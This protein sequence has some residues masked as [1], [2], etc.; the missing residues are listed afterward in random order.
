M[1]N[2]R[3]EVYNVCLAELL[4]ERGIDALPESIIRL[5]KMPDVRIFV[6][7]VRIILEGKFYNKLK[8]NEQ[9]NER[10][11]M[12]LCDI[13]IGIIYNS[14]LKNVNTIIEIKDKFLHGKFDIILC[15]QDE[16]GVINKTI[17]SADLKAIIEIIN[18]TVTLIV[19]NNVLLKM[20]RLVEEKLNILTEY[21]SHNNIWFNDKTLLK[22]LSD[23][24]GVNSS[25]YTDKTK[26]D[27]LKMTFFVLIDAMIFQESIKGLYDTVNSLDK[28]NKPLKTYFKS[29]WDEILKI[30]YKSI[31]TVSYNVIDELPNISV[32]TDYI[33]SSLKNL[34]LMIINSGI[35]TRHDFMGRIYH[36]LLLST[37][38]Q[39]YATYYTAVPS[40]YL[41]SEL[42]FKDDSFGWNFNGLE[43]LKNFRIVD[44]AC[45]SGTLLS[46]SYISLRDLIST[47]IPY[48]KIHD[49]HKVM[50]EDVIYGWDVLGY[51]THLTHTVLGLHNP[52]TIVKSSNIATIPNGIDD[53]GKIVL[54]SITIMNRQTQ[55]VNKGLIE[56]VKI[57]SVDE[58][59][60]SYDPY[61]NSIGKFDLVIMNPPFTRSA[62]T[63][64]KFGYTEK[65]IKLM[66]DKE[67]SSILKCNGL[68]GVGQAG[69]GAAFVGLSQSLLK[70]NGVLAFIVPR[71]ILSGV[72]WSKIRDGLF[73]QFEIKY[74][75]SNYDPGNKSLGIDGWSWSE[76]T[77]LG[78]VMII[79]QKTTKVLALKDT[80]Y[81][82]LINKPQ[83]EVYS[84]CYANNIKKDN[85]KEYIIS[86]HFQDIKID[87][88]TVGYYYKVNQSVLKDNW[89]APC[90]FSNPYL[91]AL[92]LSLKNELPLVELGTLIY[93]DGVDIK[94][95]KDS[96]N[97]TNT[98]TGYSILL[99]QQSAMN[100]LVLKD[101]FISY[102]IPKTN[103]AIEIYDNCKSS[104]LLSERP[105]LGND[106]LIMYYVNKQVL[107]TAFWEIQFTEKDIEKLM[108]LWF[109][110][111]FG[112]LLYLSASTSSMAGIFKTKKK[113]LE[114]M[115]VI[116]PF[117]FEKDILN[118]VNMLYNS[119]KDEEVKKFEEEFKL[120]LK[121]RGVRY[122]IDRFFI[123]LLNIKINM[124]LYYLL[125]QNEPSI[126][127]KRL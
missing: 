46:S 1:S 21:A 2:F 103:K 48:K 110:S 77:D 123:K 63:N 84:I 68:S 60:E 100:K 61:I 8:L 38:G 13:C 125:L 45:G 70:C 106:C 64:I 3:E 78:E 25:N 95:I 56:P 40:A 49:F 65:A 124:E 10:V 14:E 97:F 113:Q 108:M 105:H 69:L 47:F 120:A 34:S 50:I 16:K 85:L 66:M 67:L 92:I 96:F 79:A 75:I 54:G 43:D 74:I 83:S 80:T 51:A 71:A 37:S 42:L 17:V 121:G 7:G 116:N 33:L 76:N 91:N 101:N 31:F 59:S 27:I 122:K 115:M 87:N 72:S 90:L 9:V 24:I 86:G 32:E 57:Q 55:L 126:S 93:K 109:N 6:K 118:E 127:G 39:Y 58:C 73:N 98:P 11:Q 88:K 28:A 117:K 30:D 4:C 102:G 19:S 107:A 82:N 44:P 104:L 23:S 81:I 36:K 18:M 20:V 114:R 112:L 12:G 89:L 52:N 94:Q 35:L 15:Y 119:I 41:M 111:T 5:R 62:K 99:G 53:T 22:N 26:K 29:Q